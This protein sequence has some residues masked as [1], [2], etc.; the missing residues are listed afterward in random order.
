M[1]DKIYIIYDNVFP[2]EGEIW[3]LLLALEMVFFQ[4]VFFACSIPHNLCIFAKIQI[5]FMPL[6]FLYLFTVCI[7]SHRTQITI[8]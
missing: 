2:K 1:M 7:C 5:V 4:W 8:A 3:V 6:E